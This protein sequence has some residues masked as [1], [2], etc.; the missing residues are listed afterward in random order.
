MDF[1]VGIK[2]RARGLTWTVLAADP[3][4]PHQR[5]RLRC[6]EGDMDGLEWDILDPTEP[7]EIQSDTFRPRV[8]ASLEAWRLF[9]IAALLDQAPGPGA[10]LAT[11]PGR[12]AVEPYQLV[13]LLRALELPRPRLLLADGVGLGKT[14]QACLIATELI[15]RRQAH[16]IVVVTPSGPLLTQW[17]QELR[18][19]FGLRFTVLAD[20][21]ALRAQRR[22]L[23]RGGNPFQATPLCLTSLD[24]A[25][26]EP[27]LEELE[28]A[29]WDLAIIDEAPHCVAETTDRS[30]AATQRRRLADVLASRSDGL[31]LLTATPHDGHDAHFASLM[32]LLDP[33]LVD[34]H[35]GLSGRA[36][37]RHVV[38]RL[39]AH[40]RDPE[41]G[42]AMFQP[43][44]ITPVPVDLAGPEAEPVRDF[45]RALA[46]FVAPRLRGSGGRKRPTD[47]MAF[48][49]LLKRSVSTIRAC[50]N[51][52]RVVADRYEAA[53][54]ETEA[55]R[56]ERARALAAYRRR[57]ARYGVLDRAEE[58]DAALL[59]AE[60]MA[61]ALHDAPDQGAEGHEPADHEPADHASADHAQADHETMDH[62]TP[63]GA[64]TTQLAGLRDLIG[65]A[66]AAAPADPKL[67]ALLMEI[68]LIRAEHPGTNVLVYTEYADSL[69][70]AVECLRGAAG[71]TGEILAISGAADERQR[72]Q[73][74]ERCA[75]EDEI[76]LV[77]TDSLAEGLNL[78]RRCFHLIHLDLPYNPNRLE[79]RNGRIDRYGQRQDPDI[80]YL[81]L[82]GT[83][84]ENLLLRLI[85]KYEKARACLTVMPDTLGVTAEPDAWTK[86]L[87]AGFAEEPASL[88]PE[89]VSAV[90]TLD[91]AGQEEDS[92]AYHAL[93]REIDRAYDGF[94]PMA[95]RHGWLAGAGMG[96]GG[97]GLIA[98]RIA[99]DAGLRSLAGITPAAFVERVIGEEADGAGG[100]A[101]TSAT[102]EKIQ[103]LSLRQGE[104]LLRTGSGSETVQNSGPSAASGLQSGRLHVPMAWTHG[105]DGLPGFDPIASTLDWT[106]DFEQNLDQTGRPIGFLGV[107][108][109]LVR[110]AVSQARR[111]ETASGRD[112]RVGVAWA[113]PGADRAVMLTFAVEI[114]ARDHIALRRLIGVLLPRRGEARAMD[115]PA[116]MLALAEDASA[117]TPSD[118]WDRWFAAWVPDREADAIATANQLA[119]RMEAAFA[120][121][122]G[123]I[124]HH[125]SADLDRWLEVRSADLCGVSHAPPADLF[126]RPPPGPLWRHL[127]NPLDR[128]TG[129]AADPATPDARRRDA[130][131]VVSHYTRLAGDL[132]ARADLTEVRLLPIGLLMLVPP[133]LASTTGTGSGRSAP[134][135][136]TDDRSREP[137]DGI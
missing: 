68:R 21:A 65:L 14:I 132:A 85:A 33:S 44:R 27:V 131:S 101:P 103:Q 55:A 97:R 69:D 95:V 98:A 45:H 99:Q 76:V 40:I 2:V 77:S 30:G 24:F 74:A 128:L 135:F 66:E 53:A 16:R 41:T 49:S 115:A 61:A 63:L 87:I 119:E 96:A 127:A 43:R 94:E 106:N 89:P 29:C 10:M 125:Q 130:R 6:I 5:L 112:R 34:G 37:R 52:L 137:A 109:P 79:Q 56:R 73:A 32:G 75:T 71:I 121:T 91:R 134:G 72:S 48:V 9:H 123:R 133:D 22:R 17:E 59:E 108:H 88:F 122:H 86:G 113:A 42:Q 80:R 67:A 126:G 28:R 93:R 90:R 8:P 25:K 4:G 60:F 38:R 26:Q 39:K 15:A 117:P 62:E 100:F 46:A 129:C 84:E 58:D 20:A 36:Y 31:L 1:S 114:R 78:H 92:A 12:V 120:A 50:A 23:E 81:F 57:I 118:A 19:R 64:D 13:P 136:E 54:G 47:A 82:A 51:T 3:A 116:D 18:L 102:A 124:L 70:A 105:L 110:R 107:A 11:T 104:D 35:G 83:F 111:T 7:I